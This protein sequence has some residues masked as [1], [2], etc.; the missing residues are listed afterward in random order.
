MPANL[1]LYKLILT[2]LLFF[3]LSLWKIKVEHRKAREWMDSHPDYNASVVYEG[4]K[5]RKKNN[6]LPVFGFAVYYV[7]YLGRVIAYRSQ[8]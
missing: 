8:S 3:V 6:S 1:I 2:F 7:G 5:L 4:I